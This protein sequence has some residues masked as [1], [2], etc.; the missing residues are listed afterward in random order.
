MRYFI[1]KIYVVYL[2]NKFSDCG[3]HHA[4]L[5]YY[6]TIDLSILY[7]IAQQNKL[8]YYQLLT[9]DSQEKSIFEGIVTSIMLYSHIAPE[10]I[11]KIEI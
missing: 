5:M 8:N 2:R 9:I 6:I 3:L 10:E 11:F 7:G 4:F 1:T